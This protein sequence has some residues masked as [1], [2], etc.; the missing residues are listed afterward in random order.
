MLSEE[1][2]LWHI[3]SCV[4][5]T[6]L[7]FHFSKFKM[8][9]L[10]WKNCRRRRRKVDRLP[11]EWNPTAPSLPQMWPRASPRTTKICP[12]RFEDYSSSCK[13]EMSSLSPFVNLSEKHKLNDRRE[14]N[15][16]PSYMNVTGSDLSMANI[17]CFISCKY[18][19]FRLS[20][21]CTPLLTE[22]S[23]YNLYGRET[24]FWRIKWLRSIWGM[25]WAC[26]T[27]C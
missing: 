15:C 9:P 1:F 14:G 18:I 2:L 16:W 24:V 12:A 4:A 6:F 27:L 7:K 5:L 3:N 21:D 26:S 25:L 13:S 20:H 17:L 11:Q 23:D 19:A 8:S 10:C 22:I